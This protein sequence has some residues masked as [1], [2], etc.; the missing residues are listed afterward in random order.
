MPN[1][2]VCYRVGIEPITAASSETTRGDLVR[3]KGEVARSD[4][5]RRVFDED[6]REFECADQVIIDL[7][8][9]S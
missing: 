5:G 1:R 6:S 9:Y 7:I 3:E 8:N 2:L 4:D